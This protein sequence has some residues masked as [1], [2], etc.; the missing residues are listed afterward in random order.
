MMAQVIIS[1][2]TVKP[3]R[4]SPAPRPRS[5][6]FFMVTNLTDG[7]GGM[8]PPADGRSDRLSE[9]RRCRGMDE[10]GSM[11]V[12]STSMERALELAR[13]SVGHTEPNPR[14]G[15]VLVSADGNRVLG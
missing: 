11:N 8:P 15:C 12:S 3:R 2:M 14:V 9:W 7:E 5:P 10:N 1:S 4:R 13:R 6:L